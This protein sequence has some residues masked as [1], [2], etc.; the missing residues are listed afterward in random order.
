[1]FRFFFVKTLVAQ[2]Q[3]ELRLARWYERREKI[4]R[5]AL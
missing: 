3:A 2:G 1:M 5:F 4:P